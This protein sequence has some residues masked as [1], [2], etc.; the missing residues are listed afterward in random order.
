MSLTTIKSE[1]NVK[2]ALLTSLNLSGFDYSTVMAL[3]DLKII[4]KLGKII[5]YNRWTDEVRIKSLTF[6]I[7]SNLTISS[8][9]ISGNET[10]LKLIC[11]DIS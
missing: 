7:L 5:D 2:C 6:L 11:S 4:S 3:S 8:N 1:N 10:D 9:I